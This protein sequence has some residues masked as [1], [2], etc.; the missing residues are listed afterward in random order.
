[1]MSKKA[2]TAIV[3][4]SLI[5][6]VAGPSDC[7]APSASNDAHTFTSDSVN[8]H[9]RKITLSYSTLEGRQSDWGTYTSTDSADD[10]GYHYHTFTIKKWW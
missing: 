3:L 1:M 8:S 4:V 9:G 10:N 2:Y 6:L 5:I 7:S